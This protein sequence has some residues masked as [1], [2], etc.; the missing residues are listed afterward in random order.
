MSLILIRA[1]NKKKT[2]NT[3]ADLERH[4]K[5][6]INTKPRIL[7]SKKAE[8]VVETILKQKPKS[9]MGLSTLVKVK[10]K[11]PYTITQVMSIHPPA[12]VIVISEEYDIYTKL[13]SKFKD[14]DVLGGYY[15]S[16]NKSNKNT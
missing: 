12:H 6:N 15:S 3:L 13:E 8:L 2:L 1:S 7:D 11:T 10:E 16:K 14:L 5:L 9:S 4:A